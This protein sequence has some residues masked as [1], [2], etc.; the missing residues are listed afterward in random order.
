MVVAEDTSKSSLRTIAKSLRNDIKE[1][2]SK[3][4]II[5]K[6]ILEHPKIKSSNDILVYISI[7]NEVSTIELIKE[8]FKL[9]KNIY[10]PRIVDNYIEFYK[11][12][13]LDELELSKYNILEPKMNYKY[14]DN[15]ESVVIVPGLLFD[16]RNNRLGYGGGYYDKFLYKKDIYKIGICFSDFLVTKLITSE[17]DIKMD[18]IITER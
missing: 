6:K 5:T 1:K 2:K 7:N 11:F 12:N 14:K 9:G 16:T 15:L 4:N 10:A 17:H 13:S 18:E 8:L 3:E